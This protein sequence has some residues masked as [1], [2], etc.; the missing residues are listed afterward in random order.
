MSAHLNASFD[1]NFSQE[2]CL[3]KSVLLHSLIY[4]LTVT[5]TE[6]EGLGKN[7]NWTVCTEEGSKDIWVLQK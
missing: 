5:D 2:G 1:G 4:G 7:Q 3:L 6:L